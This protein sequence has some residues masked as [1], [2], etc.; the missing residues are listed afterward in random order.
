VCKPETAYIKIYAVFFEKLGIQS[1]ARDLCKMFKCLALLKKPL[2][3]LFALILEQ[4]F[5]IFLVM[6]QKIVGVF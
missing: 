5:T 6:M 3:F 4:G 1:K 2:I